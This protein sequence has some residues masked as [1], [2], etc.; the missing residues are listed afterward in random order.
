MRHPLAIF[1]G[2][3]AALCWGVADFSARFASRRLGAY[4]HPRLDAAF[5]FPRA[6][7]LHRTRRFA[8]SRSFRRDGSPGAL[9]MLAGLLN[10]VASLA[11]YRSFEIGM[12]SIVGPVSSSYPA[13][14]VALSLLS[15]ERI[16]AASRRRPRGHASSECF[17]RRLHLR[18]KPRRHAASGS[19]RFGDS[20]GWKPRT[21]I[22]PEAWDGPLSPRS[23]SAS[24]SGGWDF[25][26]SRVWAARF[27]SGSSA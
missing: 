16:H 3:T 25:T 4:S 10:V 20:G 15:G 1:L 27:P 19:E 2:L 18:R 5:R 22:Y 21:R 24:C 8:F 13:L 23:V 17:S 12:M 7:S 6:S 11:L 26:W 14:T 9:A